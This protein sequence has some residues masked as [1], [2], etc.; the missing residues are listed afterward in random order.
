M[1]EGR[2]I[3][4][5]T[6]K[7][8][9]ALRVLNAPGHTWPILQ[10][11]DVG[12]IAHEVVSLPMRVKKPSGTLEEG[13]VDQKLKLKGNESLYACGNSSFSVSPIRLWAFLA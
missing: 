6:F 8:L 1:G 3:A 9:S 12:D 4:N 10:L 2:D 13:V 7:L 5:K 11:A